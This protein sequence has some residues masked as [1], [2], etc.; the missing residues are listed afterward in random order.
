VC[1]EVGVVGG[2][3]GGWVRLGVG[4]EGARGQRLGERAVWAEGWDI[5]TH[6]LP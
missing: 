4:A 3:G 6:T 1:G 2:G 5:R